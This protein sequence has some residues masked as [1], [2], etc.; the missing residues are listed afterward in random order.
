MH[1]INDFSVILYMV[2]PLTIGASQAQPEEFGITQY[3]RNAMWANKNAI[4][5]LYRYVARWFKVRY[6]TL[7]YFY[8]TRSTG[9]TFPIFPIG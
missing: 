4:G 3:K 7:V 5:S 6:E 2:A 1:I 8:A 9:R